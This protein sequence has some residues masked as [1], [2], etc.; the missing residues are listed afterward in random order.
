[1]PLESLPTVSRCDG[2]KSSRA[3][4]RFGLAKGRRFGQTVCSAEED[5]VLGD[6]HVVVQAEGLG[7]VAKQEPRAAHVGE[8]IR[9]VQSD[10]SPEGPDERRR[11]VQ[12]R[13][14]A[15]SVGAD[16]AHDLTGLDG[17][18]HP[19]KDVVVSEPLSDSVQRDHGL[20]SRGIV[21]TVLPS[22]PIA[23]SGEARRK[24]WT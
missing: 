6:G 9:T 8:G 12:G 19:P 3:S 20:T 1:M 14:L 17:E 13:G 18:I 4:S 5:E 24:T 21:C 16:E 2:N 23:P 22:A 11:N 7:H 15:G 10:A